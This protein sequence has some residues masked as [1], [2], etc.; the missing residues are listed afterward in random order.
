MVSEHAAGDVVGV[1][2]Q[3]CKKR[4]PDRGALLPVELLTGVMFLGCWLSYGHSSAWLALTY[5]FML[6]GM[7]VA[8][9]IDFEHYIIPDEITI[10]GTVV[11][12]LLSLC[13][14]LHEQKT[15]FAGLWQGL[16]WRGHWVGHRV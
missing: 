9:F 6:A 15:M 3:A 16:A 1:A 14:V 4:G 2:R 8:T 11:G 13:P 5:S 12:L 10:G 7:I